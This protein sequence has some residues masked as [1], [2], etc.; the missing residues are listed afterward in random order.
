MFARSKCG[1]DCAAI[2]LYVLALFCRLRHQ[3][4]EKISNN[5]AAEGKVWEKVLSE[6]KDTSMQEMIQR[7]QAL[8]ANG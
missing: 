7:T 2:E 3:N 1:G 4:Y 5:R 6:A 8:G